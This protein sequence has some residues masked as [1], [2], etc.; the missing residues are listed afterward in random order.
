VVEE[1]LRVCIMFLSV[2][3]ERWKGGFVDMNRENE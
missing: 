1:G 3:K 2:E